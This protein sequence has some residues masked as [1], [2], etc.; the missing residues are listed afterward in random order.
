MQIS[1]FLKEMVMNMK[2]KPIGLIIG[3]I[4]LVALND[5]AMIANPIIS[6]GKPTYGSSKGTE[7]LVDGKF[8]HPAW[9]VYNG[10][11]F[12]IKVG[13]GPTRVFFNWNNPAYSWSDDIGKATSCK[14]NMSV[15]RDYD[16]LISS[17][18]TN[19]SNGQWRKVDSVRE[20]SVSERGHLIDFAGA[21]WVKMSIIVGGG[22]LDEVEIFDVSR[23]AEDIWFFPGT[24]IT[25][26]TYKESIKSSQTFA[27]LV[28]AMHPGYYPAMIR[29]GIGC[30][31]STTFATDISKYLSMTRN[32]HYWAIEMGTN[33]AWGGND[34]GVAAFI[35]NMQLIIDSCKVSGIHPIIA[36]IIATD[37]LK[38]GWQVNSVYLK[39]VDSLT[40]ANNLI[41]GPDLYTWFKQHPGDLNK[42]GVHPNSAG[43]ADIQMLWANQMSSLYNNTNLK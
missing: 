14:G 12:A 26:N 37:S 43:G 40:G 33:D 10:S 23:G 42:D 18:S 19:G 6:H 13:E 16:I 1:Y 35:K 2:V 17:N 34:S 31:N 7:V 22:T 4:L 38:A 28:A 32:A 27:G 5:M 25:A 29:G 24:S 41:P 15:P 9:P 8:N 21:S 36:R 30:I 20:N 11:W 3:I 39:A